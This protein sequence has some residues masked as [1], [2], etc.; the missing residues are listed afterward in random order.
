MYWSKSGLPTQDVSSC[1]E[2][3]A[4]SNADYKA[5]AAAGTHT[6]TITYEDFFRNSDGLEY[7]EQFY[8][9]IGIIGRVPDSSYDIQVTEQAFPSIVQLYS[10][11]TSRTSSATVSEVW[12]KTAKCYNSGNNAL[13]SGEKCDGTG[14][15]C[16]G[17]CAQGSS[18]AT[19]VGCTSLPGCTSNCE[20][21]SATT[22]TF[23]TGKSFFQLYIGTE[24]VE[25]SV[26]KRSG[27][28]TAQYRSSMT[29][30]EL[31]D[32]SGWALDWTE[33]MSQTWIDSKK[34][35]Q[36][37]D[38][39]FKGADNMGSNIAV[40]ASTRDK[41]PSTER[42]YDV[43]VSTSTSQ[44]LPVYSFQKNWVYIN[45]QASS[46]VTDKHLHITV[47]E[48]Q[49]GRDKTAETAKTKHSCTNNCEMHGT[50]IYDPHDPK[51]CQLGTCTAYCVCDYGY[52]GDTCEYAALT[53]Y[54]GVSLTDSGP[55]GNTQGSS[56]L[57]KPAVTIAMTSGQETFD[58][59]K[60]FKYVTTVSNI[61]NALVRTLFTQSTEQVTLDCSTDDCTESTGTF[62][63]SETDLGFVKCWNEQ[64]SYVCKKTVAA[65]MATVTISTANAPAYAKA[66]VYVDG[67][68]Y[69]RSGHNSFSYVEAV[70]SSADASK[71]IKLYKLSTRV[72]HTVVVI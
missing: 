42:G 61:D 39:D 13:I 9:Y 8:T 46:S 71:I 37:M 6:A 27:A 20:Q 68:P 25:M 62:P 53:A 22:S 1:C 34:D 51:H 5:M 17:Y 38:V 43:D 60:E 19:D 47:T 44:V 4:A 26:A 56:A 18:V 64:S 40:Y 3:A 65:P 2:T 58:E 15:A 28:G 49:V 52:Y 66:V 32:T 21:N 50:C 23:A 12:K 57:V 41:Y 48:S 35:E 72:E 11:T 45:V 16:S 63:A 67:Q 30:T 24:D 69:P 7:G 36:N 59:T 55:T 29:F 70:G 10:C 54:K 31:A 33:T 14:T